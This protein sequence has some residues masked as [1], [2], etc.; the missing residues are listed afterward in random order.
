M[1]SHIKPLTCDKSEELMASHDFYKT[2]HN[3][4][5]AVQLFTK[6]VI[7]NVI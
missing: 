4:K 2:V 3:I 1:L 5:N 6:E 7:N